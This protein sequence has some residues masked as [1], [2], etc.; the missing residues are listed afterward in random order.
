MKKT[1]TK[2]VLA[3]TVLASIPAMADRVKVNGETYECSNVCNV[4]VGP[5]TTVS[6]CCGGTV[7]HILKAGSVIV[8]GA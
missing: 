8:I 6:D 5:P 1:I 7:G 3:F 2:I 4:N